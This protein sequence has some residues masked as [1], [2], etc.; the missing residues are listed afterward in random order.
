[1]SNET[2]QAIADI[3]KKNNPD[4]AHVYTVEWVRDECA[5]FNQSPAE[6]LSKL[7]E[8]E[9]RRAARPVITEH[10]AWTKDLPAHYVDKLSG[11]ID[12]FSYKLMKESGELAKLDAAMDE[13]KRQEAA[14]RKAAGTDGG[15]GG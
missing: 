3:Y 15:R 14:Q 4:H 7:Q 1:M 10:Q 9:A 2:L 8:S 6:V 11:P 12:G 5:T 13:Q